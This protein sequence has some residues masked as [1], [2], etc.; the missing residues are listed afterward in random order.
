MR[1]TLLSAALA[2]SVVAWFGQTR[3]ASHEAAQAATP[4]VSEASGS[5]VSTAG[6]SFNCCWIYFGGRWWCVPC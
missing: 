6:E 2:L 4:V 3:A 5:T 1:S